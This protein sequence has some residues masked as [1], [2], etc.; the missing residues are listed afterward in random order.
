VT[1]L[2]IYDR[3]KVFIASYLTPRIAAAKALMSTNSALIEIVQCYFEEAWKKALE[4]KPE[5]P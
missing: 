2:G 5:Q 1:R 3:K 4:R